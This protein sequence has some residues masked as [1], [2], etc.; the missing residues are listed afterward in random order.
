MVPLVS[1]FVHRFA[2]VKTKKSEIINSHPVRGFKLIDGLLLDSQVRV[3][4]AERIEKWSCNMTSLY[5][6]FTVNS[7]VL[8][9]MVT[10]GVAVLLICCLECSDCS[11]REKDDLFKRNEV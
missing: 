4:F 8:A 6:W 3:E 10:V 11:C 5:H 2:I 1:P 7:S 9:V